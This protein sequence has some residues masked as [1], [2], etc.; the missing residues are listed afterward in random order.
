[1]KSKNFILKISKK[2]SKPYTYWGD[3]WYY[4]DTGFIINFNVLIGVILGFD[5][6]N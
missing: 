1:M 4:E 5:Y 2:A 6:A 3:C